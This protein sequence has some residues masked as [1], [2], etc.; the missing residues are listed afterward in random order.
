[1]VAHMSGVSHSD[2]PGPDD[3]EN[4]GAPTS[5]RKAR[6]S[7]R[8]RQEEAEVLGGLARA[9]V[10]MR[11]SQLSE[12]P[13]DAEV[14]EAVE[15][16]RG[17]RKGARVRGLR[18]ISQ[19]LRGLDVDEISRAIADASHKQ[20]ARAHRERGY[21]HWRERLLTE[22]DPALTEFIDANPHADAQR[23]R[24]L[25]RQARRA[26]ESSKG[27]QASRNVLR[28]VRD[29]IEHHGKTAGASEADDS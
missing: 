4:E 18:R 20:R 14:L 29:A 22:G 17:Y 8:E 15:A 11:P 7:Y 5:E 12:V 2:P 1:M 26:P 16:C 13:L 24:Q 9:L 23:M 27:K 28:L 21:E 25:L 6:L 19:L 10:D 3:G